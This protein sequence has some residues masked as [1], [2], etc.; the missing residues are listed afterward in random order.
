MRKSLRQKELKKRKNFLPALTIAIL[1]W[2]L[3]GFIIY[4]VDPQTFGIVP[5]LFIIT[6]FTSL[7]TFSILLGNTRRGIIVSIGLTLF[8]I[9]RYFAVGN[10]LNLFL[11][12]ATAIAVETYFWYTS[13]S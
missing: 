4:F 3:L 8:L 5:L 11:I 1:F 13:Q 6:F 7:F 10:I 9:L 2:G 12:I